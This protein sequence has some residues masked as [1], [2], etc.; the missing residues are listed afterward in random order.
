MTSPRQRPHV[1]LFICCWI[2]LQPFKLNELR[3]ISF[4]IILFAYHEFI[5][6]PDATVQVPPVILL[7]VFPAFNQT[8][9]FFIRLKI[10][11]D[12]NY[13]VSSINLIHCFT[14]YQYVRKRPAEDCFREYHSR[15]P[16]CRIV[17]NKDES[18]QHLLLQSLASLIFW[19]V[20][21]PVCGI[22]LKV[23]PS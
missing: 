8:K 14:Q 10:I 12:N 11:S 9:Q 4:I 1:W 19:T 15:E 16:V 7:T 22:F 18:V 20:R 2:R 13:S 23:L 6:K 3:F 5:S 17:W 21:F